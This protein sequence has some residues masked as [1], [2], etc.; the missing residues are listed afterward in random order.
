MAKASKG[1]KG[2]GDRAK[3][4]SASR[5]GSAPPF[6]GRSEKPGPEA[7]ATAADLCGCDLDFREGVTPD[8]ALPAARGNVEGD[9]DAD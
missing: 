3:A 4:P 2:G 7:A 9:R 8:D 5:K 6:S 1:G